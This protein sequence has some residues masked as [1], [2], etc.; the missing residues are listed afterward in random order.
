MSIIRVTKLA[1]N[2]LPDSGR[3][4]AVDACKAHVL[5]LLA[6]SIAFGCGRSS[7]KSPA[8]GIDGASDLVELPADLASVDSASLGGVDSQH[9]GPGGVSTWLDVAPDGVH[10]GEAGDVSQML[11]ATTDGGDHE[12][13]PLPTSIDSAPDTMAGLACDQVV[14]AYSAF[15]ATHRDCSSTSDCQV[16]GGAGTCN[17]VAMLGNGSGDAISVTALS[18]AY[19]YLERARACIQQG[20]RFPAPCDAAPAKNLRCE[21]GKCTADQASCLVFGG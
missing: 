2:V 16:V 6:G 14:S 11:D 9:D 3:A 21:N 18:D 5:L 17:C 4:R 12:A 20:F 1:T 10:W 8:A 19:A 13:G 15:L 7:G